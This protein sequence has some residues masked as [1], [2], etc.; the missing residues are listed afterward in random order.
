MKSKQESKDDR[1]V[2]IAHTVVIL[3]LLA[4][5]ASLV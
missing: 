1:T 3:V 4:V 2:A 5:W